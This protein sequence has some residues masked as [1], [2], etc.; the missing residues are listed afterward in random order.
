MICPMCKDVL[1]QPLE[2]P[3]PGG[4]E[5]PCCKD[6]WLQWLP[7]SPTCPVCCDP[8]NPNKLLP[9]P[10]LAWNRLCSMQ[11]HCDYWD[12]GC[13]A[14]VQLDKL[15]DHTTGCPFRDPAYRLPSAQ[16]SPHPQQAAAAAE[17]ASLQDVLCTPLTRPLSREEDRAL[18]NL[19]QRKAH[20]MGSSVGLPV[21][22]GGRPR[23][24]SFIPSSSTAQPSHRT[25]QR[26]Q[27]VTRELE[28]ALSS[29]STD[30]ARKQRRFNV[31]HSEPS[32]RADLLFT[33]KMRMTV[34]QEDTMAM[35]LNLRL[36]NDQQRKLR[37]WT[38]RWN[39]RLAS[40]RQVSS[41]GMNC[42]KPIIE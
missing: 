7:N 37:K 38:E 25:M 19:L 32:E 36:S 5:H 4:C 15:N 30:Q 10:R 42:S 17:S 31:E 6:C 14:V 35:T 22:T 23:Q 11:L 24:V 28:V 34:S 41:V 12:Q 20:E 27:H 3:L 29:G 26:R 33:A 2:A 21:F 1:Q 8:I 9:L 16:R 40:E 13:Q 39:L 18:G